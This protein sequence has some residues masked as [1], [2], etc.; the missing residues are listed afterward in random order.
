M[1][2]N[3][4][5]FRAALV[6]VLLLAN[7][8]SDD[9]APSGPPVLSVAAGDGQTAVA[10]TELPAQIV[11]ELRDAKQRPMSGIAVVWTP[12]Q[13]GHDVVIPTAL[14]TDGAGYARA[15]WQLDTVA[16]PHSLT[17]T[18]ANGVS[19]HVSAFANARPFS[20]V[21]ELPLVTYD[22][23]GQAVH[24]DFVRLPAS[25]GG[26]PFR[27]VATPYPGGD[28]TYEN[29]SLFTGSTGTSWVVP[30]GIQNPL[31]RPLSGYYSDPDVLYDVIST[32]SGSSEQLKRRMK[33][34][35]IAR[36]FSPEGSMTLTLKDIRVTLELAAKTMTPMPY[37]SLLREQFVTAIAK[38]W[39]A[40]D[41]A[42]VMKVLELA[43]GTE[44]RRSGADAPSD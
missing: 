41:W 15:R 27:L 35:I 34:K 4:R 2:I 8:C 28:Q 7:A 1:P 11:V 10:A 21:A 26:D 6:A 25:W 20:N 38:G 18:T 32:N 19:A 24:P 37:G 3:I 33:R 5:S 14:V 22:G 44:V 36:D 42:C 23:S 17:V 13:T 9:I 43:T 30:D 12:Q 39:G 40:E 31:E 29:P 16:G